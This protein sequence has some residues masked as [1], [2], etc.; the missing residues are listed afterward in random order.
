MSALIV[1]ASAHL[2]PRPGFEL[3]G[4]IVASVDVL[5]ALASAGWT[6]GDVLARH[7]ASRHESV[8]ETDLEAPDGARVLAMTLS[9]A[10]TVPTTYLSIDG[11]KVLPGGRRVAAAVSFQFVEGATPAEVSRAKGRIRTWDR[12]GQTMSEA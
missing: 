9:S 10:G 2:S 11:E 1:P 6:V 5:A 3:L 7:L 4:K 8:W 12:F